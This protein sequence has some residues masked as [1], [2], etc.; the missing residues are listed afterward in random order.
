L[1]KWEKTFFW[2]GLIIGLVLL[3]GAVWTLLDIRDLLKGTMP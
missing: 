2:T 3:Y 1:G